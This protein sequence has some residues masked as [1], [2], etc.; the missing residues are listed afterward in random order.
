MKNLNDL[1]E[2]AYRTAIEHGWHEERYSDEH[3]LCLVISE[4]MEAVN[5][6]RKNDHARLDKYKESLDYYLHEVRLYGKAYDTAESSLYDVFLKDT[7]EDELCDACIRLFDY[8]GVCN[9][10]LDE[11]DYDASDSTDFSEMSF[12]ESI[13]VLVKSVMTG[14]IHIALNDIFAFCK[15]LNID[16]FWFIDRKMKYNESRAYKH[17]KRY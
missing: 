12:T 11:F 7:V 10:D 14:D 1:K 6:D 15:S 5:A 17:G 16:I 13:Y 8:A 3:W 2:R 9:C 4:L